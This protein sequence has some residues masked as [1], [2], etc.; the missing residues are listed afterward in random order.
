MHAFHLFISGILRGNVTAIAN[1]PFEEIRAVREPSALVM[2][3]NPHPTNSLLWL[4]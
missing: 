2:V 4:F 3:H 1:V